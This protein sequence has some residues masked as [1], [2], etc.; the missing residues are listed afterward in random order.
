MISFTHGKLKIELYDSIHELPMFRSAVL[1]R[2]L[3][4]SFH[5]PSQVNT[6]AEG[7][8]KCLQLLEHQETQPAKTLLYNMMYGLH[9]CTEGIQPR[10]MAL[11]ALIYRINGRVYDDMSDSGLKE[12]LSQIES[13]P[14]AILNQHLD[15]VKKNLK[16]SGRYSSPTFLQVLPEN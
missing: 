14:E 8:A 13:I 5:V 4:M 9:V 7:L 16:Q 10:A 12:T 11:A 6:L 2:Y 3:N 1:D 15:S